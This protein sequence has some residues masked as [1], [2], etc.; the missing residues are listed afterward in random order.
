MK[1]QPG[2]FGD[3]LILS[4]DFER[5]TNYHFWYYILMEKISVELDFVVLQPS[6]G[7][8]MF[9]CCQAGDKGWYQAS[10]S[11]LYMHKC[12]YLSHFCKDLSNLL[13]TR[14]NIVDYYKAFNYKL[15]HFAH[16]YKELFQE[17]LKERKTE[18]K[19]KEISKLSCESVSKTQFHKRIIWHKTMKNPVLNHP[20]NLK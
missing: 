8:M 15:R 11:R 6:C 2:E 9:I 17:K 10:K 3:D 19:Q 7:P 16:N 20:N 5:V 4:V 12:C 13:C 1:T 14:T 18:A